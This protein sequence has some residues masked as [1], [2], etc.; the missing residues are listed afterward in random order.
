MLVDWVIYIIG[1]DEIVKQGTTLLCY[2]LFYKYS[3]NRAALPLPLE[4]GLEANVLTNRVMQ[5]YAF[6]NSLVETCTLT[7]L[8]SIN[9]AC[10]I[11]LLWLC[12]AK[13][14]Y[15]TTNIIPKPKQ[16]ILSNFS[17]PSSWDQSVFLRLIKIYYYVILPK[18]L[19]SRSVNNCSKLL[20]QS[21]C[22]DDGVS[23]LMYC[24]LCFFTW[25]IHVLN[26][27][28]NTS[29]VWLKPHKIALHMC[30]FFSWL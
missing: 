12:S 15:I 22:S 29:S 17:L 14:R 4:F 13:E 16:T 9:I 28:C 19:T 23:L 3:Q 7:Y 10:Y 8:H 2:Y 18:D 25:P 1:D 21:L 5:T 27:A 24:F 20:S 6:T 30:D 26:M 11:Q